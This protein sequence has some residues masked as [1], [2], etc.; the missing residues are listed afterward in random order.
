ME[1][2]IWRRAR[3]GCVLRRSTITFGHAHP[4]GVHLLRLGTP[5]ALQ[6]HRR[7]EDGSAQV[8][9]GHAYPFVSDAR[10]HDGVLDETGVDSGLA[11]RADGHAV[12]TSVGGWLLMCR[13]RG[14]QGVAGVRLMGCD[15]DQQ[16]AQGAKVLSASWEFGCSP[17]T[18]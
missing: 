5:S 8:L 3:S 16:D 11:G 4:H 18:T 9:R 12:L 15:D 7:S 2:L 1:D 17:W 10:R 6:R 13:R 14:P